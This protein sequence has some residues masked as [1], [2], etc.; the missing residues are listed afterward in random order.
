[1]LRVRTTVDSIFTDLG[2]TADSLEKLKVGLLVW[3]CRVLLVLV[4]WWCAGDTHTPRQ[5]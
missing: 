5:P 4:C 3:L 1:M 2:I